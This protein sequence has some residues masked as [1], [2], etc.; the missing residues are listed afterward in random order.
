[1]KLRLPAT[2]PKL[3]STISLGSKLIS[4]LLFNPSKPIHLLC[5]P[6]KYLFVTFPYAL[7]NSPHIPPLAVNS[8]PP[9]NSQ[10]P[11]DFVKCWCGY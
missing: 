4:Y 5:S 11:R 3:L 9:R 2:S 10:V 6:M 7:T 8:I 1:M